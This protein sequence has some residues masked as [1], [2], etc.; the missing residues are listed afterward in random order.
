MALAPPAS[1][2]QPPADLPPRP[3]GVPERE[4]HGEYRRADLPPRPQ[5][6]LKEK[7]TGNIVALG[8][9]WS[10]VAAALETKRLADEALAV[11][12]KPSPL[13]FRG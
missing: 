10:E 4:G 11:R 13:G 8:G 5:G 7:D 12:P 3:Q 1:P 2:S 6:S 9:E